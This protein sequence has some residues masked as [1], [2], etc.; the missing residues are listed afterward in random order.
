MLVIIGKSGQL[1]RKCLQ[2]AGADNA[3]CLGRDD[4]DITS[5][6]L[7]QTLHNISP[8]AIINA[9]AYT[10]VD[11]AESEKEKALVLNCKAVEILSDHC[12]KHNIHFVHVS[13]DY[14]FRGDKGSPYLPEDQYDPVNVY[15]KTKMLGEQAIQK[16]NAGGSCILRTSWVYSEFSGNFVASMLRLMEEKEELRIISDQIGSPTSVDTLARACLAA[17]EHKLTGIHH[18][19]DEGVASWFDF[20]K[21]IQRLALEHGLLSKAIPITP[22]NTADYPT[23]AK[24]PS[25]SVLSKDSFKAALPVI[26]LPY[27]EESL[28]KV[29]VE[30]KAKKIQDQLN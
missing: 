9:S 15:G 26:E 24:R 8:T 30:I 7:L 10:A 4:I 21:S 27:W 2:L 14:V 17:A 5:E 25:Y 6:S 23:P 16:V 29:L 18:L 1:A 22:I 11:L 13:T 20:A 19:T 12:A 3:V 28:E